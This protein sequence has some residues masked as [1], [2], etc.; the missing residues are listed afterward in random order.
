MRELEQKRKED[1][2]RYEQEDPAG[3]LPPMHRQEQRQFEEAVL[4]AGALGSAA[5]C[6]LELSR[7]W[8]WSQT[9][10]AVL[11]AVYLPQG[12]DQ[13]GADIGVEVEGGWAA[14]LRVGRQGCLPVVH[15]L[16][17]GELDTSVPAEVFRCDASGWC[18]WF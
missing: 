8:M 11:V 15:R 18:W 14:A 13:L 5:R 2:L 7:Y 6:P 9:E 17:E 3:R 12:P 16:L 10:A 4:R 1:A